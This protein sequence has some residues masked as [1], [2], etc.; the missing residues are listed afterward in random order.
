[1]GFNDKDL[2]GNVVFSGSGE[3]FEEYFQFFS[4]ADVDKSM[5]INGHEVNYTY[6]PEDETHCFT[7]HS[8]TKSVSDVK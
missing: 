1:M 2:K 7:I 5:W 3:I 8:N 4:D 6:L